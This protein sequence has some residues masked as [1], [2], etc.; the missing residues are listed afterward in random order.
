M[1]F[2]G[3]PTSSDCSDRNAPDRTMS[4]KWRVLRPEADV[5]VIERCSGHDGTYGVKKEYR[6]TSMKIGKPVFSRVKNAAP[7]YYASDCPMAASG[8]WTFCTSRPARR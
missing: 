5:K 3:E 2:S 7:D 6:E 8:P 4:S 1:S